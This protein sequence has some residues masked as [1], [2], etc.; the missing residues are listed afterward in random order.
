MSKILG[1][2]AKDLLV[3]NHGLG[4]AS[5]SGFGVLIE[6]QQALGMLLSQVLNCC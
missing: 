6:C 2:L 3:Q 4:S 1:E 5:R